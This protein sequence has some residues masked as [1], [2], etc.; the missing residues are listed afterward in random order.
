MK[1]FTLTLLICILILACSLSTALAVDNSQS[2]SFDLTV[3]GGSTA[4]VQLGEV[5]TVTLTLTRTDASGDYTLYAMQDE[6]VFDESRFELVEDSLTTTT[7]F[8]SSI[9]TLSDGSSKVYLNASNAQGIQVSKDQEIGSFQLKAIKTGKASVTNTD[10][11]VVTENAGDVYSS[12][13]QNLSLTVVT[14]DEDEDEDDDDDDPDKSDNSGGDQHDPI[15][16]QPDTARFVDVPV[17]HWSYNYI[18]YLAGKGIVTG[19]TANMF[20]PN[21][22]ITRAEFVTMLARMSGETLPACD[23]RFTDVSAD[24]YYA[25][26]VSWAVKI[27]VTNGTSATTFSPNKQILR[28]EIAAMIY[29]YAQYM[30]CSFA[31]VNSSVKFTDQ[32]SIQD[33]ALIPISTMQTAGIIGGYGDGSFKPLGFATRAESAKM[34]ALVDQTPQK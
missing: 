10:Y 32:T 6:I 20:Y 24:T 11:K 3:D 8:N 29:R 15:P 25:Q 2:Y 23:G 12:A 17:S 30:G 14:E 28:Q 34:L 22:T 33:Y 26:A 21:A 18:E 27:G 4:A 19:K 5:V 7:N 13:S 31:T 16:S 9:R 1:Q